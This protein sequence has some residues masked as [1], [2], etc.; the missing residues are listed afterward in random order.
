VTTSRRSS[1]PASLIPHFHLAAAIA[2]MQAE[3]GAISCNRHRD[4]ETPLASAVF[5]VV[6]G[7]PVLLTGFLIGR[8]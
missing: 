4:L 1:A 8:P 5:R 2:A 6:V 3:R 7:L